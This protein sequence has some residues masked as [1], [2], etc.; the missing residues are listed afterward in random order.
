MYELLNITDFQMERD[1]YL[2]NLKTGMVE[3]CFDDSVGS[4]NHSFEFM[5]ISKKYNCKIRLVGDQVNKL[6]ADTEEIMM[7]KTSMQRIGK[8]NFLRVEVRENEYYV[9][10]S[11][12]HLKG[13]YPYFFLRILRKDLLEVDGTV[14]YDFA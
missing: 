6:D 13:K 10:S 5:E 4:S 1:V 12:I 2:K 9:L 14:S 7:N 3:R 11:D 8:T